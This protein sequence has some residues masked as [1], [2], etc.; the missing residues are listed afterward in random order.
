MQHPDKKK[1]PKQRPAKLDEHIAG[2]GDPQA[3][4]SGSVFCFV[5]VWLCVFC[6]VVCFFFSGCSCIFLCSCVCAFFVTIVVVADHQS[7]AGVGE[8]KQAGCFG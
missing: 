3:S 1:A 7:L 5:C 8:K 6:I 4:Y 2:L